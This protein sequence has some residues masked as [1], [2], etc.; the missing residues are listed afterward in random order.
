MAVEVQNV[1]DDHGGRQ[2]RRQRRRRSA[3]VQPAAQQV[4]VRAGMSIKDDDLTVEHG[5][6][7]LEGRRA[8]FGQLGEREAAL[9]KG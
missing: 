7:P 6:A 1:K 8:R 2:S 9:I 4:K 3:R 5:G